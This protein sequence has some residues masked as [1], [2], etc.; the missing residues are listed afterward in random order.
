[1]SDNAINID[2]LIK[3]L[4]YQYSI[5]D[6]LLL[7]NIKTL[8]PDNI[9][10]KYGLIFKGEAIVT[11][12]N[13]KRTE[14]VFFISQAGDYKV[15]YY[16]IYDG[17]M[18]SN[19]SEGI[20][21]CDSNLA[22]YKT[23]IDYFK[24]QNETILSE[25][26][27]KEK[28]RLLGIN[29]GAYFDEKKFAKRF[30]DFL[31]KNIDGIDITIPFDWQFEDAEDR[32]I[33]YRMHGFFFQTALLFKYWRTE[34]E[35]YL[36]LYFKYIFDWI[37]KHSIVEL[38]DVWAWHDDTTARRTYFFTVTL[39]L[40]EKRLSEEQICIL[41]DS[42]NMQVRVMCHEQ[43]YKYHHNHGM[44]Q[45][46]ALAFYGLTYADES[47][48]YLTM[49]MERTKEYFEFSFT[50][51]GVHKEH[52]PNYH[53]DMA[54]S[55]DWFRL[56]Y[57]DK[58]PEFSKTMEELLRQMSEYILWV[59]MPDQSIPSI[60][61]SAKRR[62]AIPLWNGQNE[63]RYM[64]T[65]GKEGTEPLQ[66]GKV[67]CE[68]GYGVIRKDWSMDGNGTW[69][70]LLAAT[71]SMAH[72]HN[73]DLSFLLYHKGELFTE[74]GNRD[75][76]YSDSMTEYVYTSYAHNVLL[77]NG[78][79]WKMKENHLP[80]LEPEAYDTKITE[81]C[82]DGQIQYIK[83]IQTRFPGV[84]QQRTLKYY[85]QSEIVQII[86]DITL[87]EDICL[88]L[89]YHLASGLEILKMSN[90]FLVKRNSTSIA[91]IFFDGSRFVSS[92]LIMG[93]DSEKF[94]TW[95]FNGKTK[96][97]YGTVLKISLNGEKGDNTISCFV[98]LL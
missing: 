62:R 44:Y 23:E 56:A 30:E 78:E 46:R 79:G 1:M 3:N 8:I 19:I 5:E 83:G 58:S 81:A 45:D 51:D 90:Y 35:R 36:D 16:L 66:T 72:K 38:S 7:F 18:V 28:V 49:A 26:S 68:A 92:T 42:I 50:K 86:D 10:L 12:G 93:N 53:M 71:H 65:N 74:A 84:V 21:I 17:K 31:N 25:Y 47:D 33:P 89:I 40:F 63:Y 80:Y 32:N 27:D 69:M 60:G 95:L 13:T 14:H 54:Y 41:K 4:E 6:G 2:L 59:T 82:V 94:K 37:E 96:P 75:Y 85:R 9:L 15:K 97:Q 61:D 22:V 24:Y 91:K 48:Y 64:I 57:R 70:M 73:D 88:N 67:F 77:I 98:E 76:N 52:S 34:N 55:I 39:F 11:S 20:T 43:F 87:E 29:D